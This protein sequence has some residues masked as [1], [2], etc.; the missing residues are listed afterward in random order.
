MNN[1]KLR[2]IGI[3][4]SQSVK[5]Y[6]SSGEKDRAKIYTEIMKLCHTYVYFY[7]VNI[8]NEDDLAESFSQ[9]IMKNLNSSIK[10][11]DSSKGDFSSF[12]SSYI[13]SGFK[14]FKSKQSRNSYSAEVIDDAF[15]KDTFDLCHWDKIQI[16]EEENQLTR[17]NL[18][19]SEKRRILAFMLTMARDMDEVYIT[20]AVSIFGFR[21]E[22]LRELI[23]RVIEEDNTENSKDE[24][25]V[26]STTLRNIYYLRVL[27]MN[28]INYGFSISQY[29]QKLLEKYKKMVNEHNAKIT[30]YKA[31]SQKIVAK[32]L[33]IDYKTIRS[34]IFRAKKLI[35]QL[36]LESCEN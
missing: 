27:R 35:H 23:N 34:E 4:L 2:E 32:V 26:K 20:R 25:I 19:E 36:F 5:L 22:E 17:T 6:K 15:N 11:Y 10:L 14:L 29:D 31:I 16:D 7:T 12:I 8:L 18:K 28:K 13:L 24:K 33:D 9:F 30:K 21:E 3:L 1:T